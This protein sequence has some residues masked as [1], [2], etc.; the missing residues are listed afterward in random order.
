MNDAD[1]SAALHRDAELAGSPP[2]DLI[3][4]LTRRRQHQRRQR[5]GV[6]AAVLG[7]VVVAGGVPLGL[8]LLDRPDGGTA[9]TP[10]TP[11]SST[12]APSTAAPSTAAPSTAAPSTAASSSVPSSAALP[13]P[14]GCPGVAAL[15]ELLPPESR[16][17]GA[18]AAGTTAC[19]G[20]WALIGV[21]RPGSQSVALFRFA[22]GSWTPVDNTTACAGGELPEDLAPSVCDAG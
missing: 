12:A 8:S 2:A 19:S 1:L 7:V 10:S 14:P 5:A 11:T 4:Q 3:S 20:D 21:M 15:F 13:A 17:D 16:A 6:A 9:T 18:R 22:D